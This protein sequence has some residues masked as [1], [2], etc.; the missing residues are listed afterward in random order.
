[1]TQDLLLTDLAATFPTLA[2][3]LKYATTDNITGHAIYCEARALLHPEAACALQKSVEVARLAGLTLLVFDA[4]R[5][6][7]AQWHLWDAC[8]DADYVV[9]PATGSNHSRGVAI[10]LTLVDDAGNVLD[11]GTAFDSMEDL[12]HPFHP[13]V[14]QQAQRHRLMLNAIM[15]AGGFVGMPTEWWHFELPNA[16]RY[17]LLEDRF[18]CVAR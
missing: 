5:P 4:Y 12:S 3:D 9:P 15:L 10:D 7:Q 1:M 17:P 14:P 11:M 18:G 6:Q 8:P 13:D 2:F 16:Q